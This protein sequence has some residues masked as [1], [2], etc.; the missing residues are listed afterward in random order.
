MDIFSIIFGLYFDNICASVKWAL[1][2]G[3]LKK[4]LII[5][6]SLML[7]TFGSGCFGFYMEIRENEQQQL[8][9][10]NQIKI[11]M[12]KNERRKREASLKTQVDIALRRRKDEGE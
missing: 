6:T 4:S 12:Q 7:I 11:D 8:E 5:Y 1:S 2:D 3:R 9:L 10:S